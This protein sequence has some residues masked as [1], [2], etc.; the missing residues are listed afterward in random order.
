M[1]NFI[2]QT[3]VFQLWNALEQASV[4][5]TGPDCCRAAERG[6]S[7]RPGGSAINA[8]LSYGYSNYNA[9]YTTFKTQ[10]W[11][12]IT[13]LSNFTWGRSLGTGQP[14]SGVFRIHGAEPL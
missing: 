12:G 13:T 2:T 7:L 4:L 5:E 6:G 3:Q 10:D 8:D 9:L 14:V 11:H 1:N